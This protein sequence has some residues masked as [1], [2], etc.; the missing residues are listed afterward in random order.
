MAGEEAGRWG[1]A[2]EFMATYTK[3]F[4]KQNKTQCPSNE[5]RGQ[6]QKEISL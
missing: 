4:R 5:D 3:V 2:W 6:A 1:S